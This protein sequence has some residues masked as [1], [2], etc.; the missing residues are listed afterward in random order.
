MAKRELFEIMK[1]YHIPFTKNTNG[2]FINL[3]YLEESSI[4]CLF[5]HCRF[6]INSKKFTEESRKE[7]EENKKGFM[8][9]QTL[10]QECVRD[11]IKDSLSDSL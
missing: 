8:I 3:A 6:F 2:L 7:P 1:T 4:Q 10:L 11:I 5:K 9:D